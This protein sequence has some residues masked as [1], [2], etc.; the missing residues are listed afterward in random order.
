M[1]TTFDQYVGIDYSGS[2]TPVSRTS[3][4]QIF[5]ATHDD[6]Q[7]QR[8]DSPLSTP[9]RRRHWCRREVAQ[10]LIETARSGQSV[11]AG[12]DHGFS[13][14]ISYYHR[15][16]LNSWHAFVDDFCLHW[17]TDGD[18]VTVD[19]IR[20]RYSGP[21]PRT[22]SNRDLRIT[23]RWT[24]SAMSVFQFGV[25]GAVASSTHAGIPWLRHIRRELGSKVHVWPF[26]GWWVPADRLVLA[27]VYPSILRRRYPRADRSTDEQDAWSVARWLAETAGNDLLS[28]YLKPPMNSETRS[29]AELEGWILGVA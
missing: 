5:S 29:V 21:P 13:V 3:A 11:I 18:D 25:R 12:I 8:I 4:I 20:K 28:H 14:P 27:E 16:R 1:T 10:W 23:E 24:S 22:G 2:R 7:P 9:R 19:S 15:Y 17:P 26:D 6:T